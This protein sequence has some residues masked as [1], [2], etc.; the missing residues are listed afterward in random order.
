[1]VREITGRHEVVRMR[2]SITHP[3]MEFSVHKPTATFTSTDI[4]TVFPDAAALPR[5]SIYVVTTFQPYEDNTTVSE[6]MI[7]SSEATKEFKDL[8]RERF[9]SFMRTLKEKVEKVTSSS[10][11]SVSW[12]DW[13]DPATGIPVLGSAGP[14]IYCESDALE[15][16]CSVDVEVV[17]GA[18]GACRMVQHPKWGV[19]VYPASGFLS[20]PDQETLLASLEAI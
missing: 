7:G 12:V 17:G 20:V 15:Q 2:S 16:L 14:A 18:G 3:P 11:S 13:T 6:T 8:S 9:F 19:N 1:M 10:S 5:S 4:L